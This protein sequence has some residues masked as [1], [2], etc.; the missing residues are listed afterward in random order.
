MCAQSFFV[1]LLFFFIEFFDSCRKHQLDSVHL[2]DFAGAWIVIHRDNV[3][4]GEAAAQYLDDTFAD[5]VVRQ[6]GEWL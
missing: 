5:N 6:A 4:F 1:L 2:I 3:G